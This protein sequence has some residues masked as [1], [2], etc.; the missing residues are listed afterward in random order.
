MS[1]AAARG[2]DPRIRAEHDERPDASVGG[3]RRARGQAPA[4][5]AATASHERA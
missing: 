5:A 1:G 4:R 3:T 2:I